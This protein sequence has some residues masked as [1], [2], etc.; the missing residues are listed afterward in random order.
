MITKFQNWS[1]KLFAGFYESIL[2]NSNTLADISACD[3]LKEGFSYNFSSDN[4]KLYEKNVSTKAV[5]FLWDNLSQPDDII[6]SM[7]FISITSPQYYNFETDKLN[8]KIDFNLTKLKKYCFNT[9][10]EEFNQY[11]K[12]TYTSYDGFISFISNNIKDF[13]KSYKDDTDRSINVM[14]E[15]Y[16]LKNTNL[17]YYEDDLMEYANEAVYEYADIYAEDDYECLNPIPYETACESYA[18]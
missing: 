6:K 1:Y 16:L 11:L 2:Y 8:I 4:Y 12:D 15:F 14:I 5:Q 9:E 18:L 7:K 17:E 10:K 3:N 13:K